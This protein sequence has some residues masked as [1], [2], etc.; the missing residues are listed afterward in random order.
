MVGREKELEE[1]KRQLPS[2]TLK[3]VPEYKGSM[4]SIYTS[5]DSGGYILGLIASGLVLN[6][7][8]NNFHILYI[9]FG[10]V[11]IST[12]AVVFFFAEDPCKRAP[13]Q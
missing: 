11:G 3:Q 2:L 7:Y 8:A 13:T 1:L 12:A 5:F 10:A 6:L 4:M 9:I